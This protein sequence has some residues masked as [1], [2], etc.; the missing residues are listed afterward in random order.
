MDYPINMAVMDTLQDLLYAVAGG[1]R[2][3]QVEGR[4]M[5]GYMEEEREKYDEEAGREAREM[6]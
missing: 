2:M 6:N 1:G 5:M 4:M 3:V